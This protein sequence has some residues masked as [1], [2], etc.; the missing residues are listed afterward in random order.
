MDVGEFT[1]SVIIQGLSIKLTD[2]LAAHLTHLVEIY[3]Q[4]LY[5]DF[6]IKTTIINISDKMLMYEILECSSWVKWPSF[7]AL[8]SMLCVKIHLRFTAFKENKHY[9]TSCRFLKFSS[10]IRASAFSTCLQKVNQEWTRSLKHLLLIWAEP[11][12][13]LFKSVSARST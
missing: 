2:L 5:R 1:E 6:G 11:G 13:P 7:L 10:E 8:Q 9:R 12:T 4:W 3:H